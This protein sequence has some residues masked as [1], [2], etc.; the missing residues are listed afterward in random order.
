[1]R[2]FLGSLAVAIFVCTGNAYACPQVTS[3]STAPVF[4][5]L[6]RWSPTYYCAA[7]PAPQTIGDLS[8]AGW[9]KHVQVCTRMCSYQQLSPGDPNSM[10]IETS[11]GPGY[12]DASYY[13]EPPQPP[14][15][16]AALKLKNPS[17]SE[18]APPR[19]AATPHPHLNRS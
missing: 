2:K 9:A 7:S 19:A 4:P 16:Y 6:P 14:A 1:M 5:A 12:H 3:A 13:V 15:G 10:L 8:Y 17:C 11:C 18:L